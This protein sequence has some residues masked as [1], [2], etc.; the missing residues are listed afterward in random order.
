MVSMLIN[1]MS[2][3]YAHVV[4][5]KEVNSTK[6]KLNFLNEQ[7]GAL[8]FQILDKEECRNVFMIILKPSDTLGYD[9]DNW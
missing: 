5:N 3:I 9:E 2:D 7:A 1:V 6:T 4:E 8:P